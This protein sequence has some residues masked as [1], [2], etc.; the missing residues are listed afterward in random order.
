MVSDGFRW[1]QMVAGIANTLTVNNLSRRDPFGE[2]S[3][4]KLKPPVPKG[5]LSNPKDS[6]G[7]ESYGS[8]EPPD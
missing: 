2:T 8:G 7:K 5:S 4:N 3:W 1:F 6:F